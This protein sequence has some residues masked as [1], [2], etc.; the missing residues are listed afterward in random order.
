M[1]RTFDNI[2][3]YKYTIAEIC[4][5]DRNSEWRDMTLEQLLYMNTMIEIEEYMQ[6]GGRDV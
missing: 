3:I 6:K 4:D 2:D 1:L 5:A